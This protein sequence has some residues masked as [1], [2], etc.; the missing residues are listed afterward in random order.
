[1]KLEKQVTSF[2]DDPNLPCETALKKMYKL[3]E[4]Y[5]F[6]CMSSTYI[7]EN[8]IELFGCYI[9]FQLCVSLFILF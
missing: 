4:K 3:L 5:V 8:I 6:R 1:M 9:S 7:E 2:V